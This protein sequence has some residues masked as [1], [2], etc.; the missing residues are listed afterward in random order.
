MFQI[1]K[2]KS[3]NLSAY[4]VGI[5]RHPYT[6]QEADDHFAELNE[7][8]RTMGMPVAGSEM[9][10]INTPTAQLLMGSGKAEAIK[11]NAEA[12]EANVIIIDDELSP[13]QQ[14]NW[15]ELTEKAVI[16]RREVILD[17]FKQRAHTREA[18]LQVDLAKLEY[19]LPRLKRAWT[20]LERQRGGG[21]F[22]GG[23]GEAQIEVDRRLVR[24]SIAQLKKE[25]ADVRSRRATQRKS[26]Q[27]KPVPT[28]AL[29]GYTNAGKSSVLNALTGADV[30]AED[31]LFAT[32]DPTTR[33]IT[34]INKQEML[35]TDTVGFIRKLP[36]MLVDA[37]KATL[38]EAELADLLLHVV[39]ASHP[40]A[41]DHITA[42]QEV[43]KELHADSNPMLYLLNKADLV[44]DEIA[45]AHLQEAARPFIM[46]S[47]MTGGGMDELKKYLADFAAKDLAIVHV[48]IPS[49]R[50]D[51]VSF[52]HREGHVLNEKY[53][54][55][56]AVLE[57]NLPMKFHSR[58]TE[59]LTPAAKS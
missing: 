14:R 18:Q 19:S 23:A 4:L 3:E 5:R 26:R 55:D 38:E 6:Q 53:E 39:D 44:T 27:S 48:R 50:H 20:H 33:R 29:V 56:E 40:N 52:L 12:K 42:T 57:V 34:L 8:V 16:D 21:G 13:A 17:I 35:L 36:H 22:T 43:L 9:V 49:T 41:I 58:V 7:L 24:D 25:L 45:L 59:F 15:E 47:T 32:L 51:I 28:A 54:D 46:T 2:K 30:L 31:K 11:L 10:N 1:E 37:F